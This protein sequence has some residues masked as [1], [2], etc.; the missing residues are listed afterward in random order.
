[1]EISEPPPDPE[2]D[3]MNPSPYL[4][5]GKV[6]EQLHP[7]TKEVV[8]R[9]KSAKDASSAM[10]VE[11]AKLYMRCFNHSAKS[12]PL[13]NFYWRFYSPDNGIEQ[14]NQLSMKELREIR[15]NDMA[16]MD[17]DQDTRNVKRLKLTNGSPGSTA[18]TKDGEYTSGIVAPLSARHKGASSGR[19]VEQLDLQTRRVVRR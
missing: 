7:E 18:E 2:F 1:M 14:F 11:N 5:K 3:P 17:Y 16:M 12:T 10:S 15:H 13:G 4:V 19:M 8:R 6:I 9:Y